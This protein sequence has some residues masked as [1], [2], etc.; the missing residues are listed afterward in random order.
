MERICAATKPKPTP[1]I[2]LTPSQG[3]EFQVLITPLWSP[4]KNLTFN[5]EDNVRTLVQNDL[6]EMPAGAVEKQVSLQKFKGING[7]GYHFLVTD[8]APKA[9]DYS[10][11]VRAGV[12]VGDLLLSVTILSRTKDS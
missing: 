1:T 3:D 5:K 10:Y 8:K 7:T 4:D 2:I 6:K 12:G 9:G 11:A